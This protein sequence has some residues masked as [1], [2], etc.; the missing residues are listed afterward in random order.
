MRD[1]VL[2]LF[3]L[4]SI[5][6][7]NLTDEI[8]FRDFQSKTENRNNKSTV[9]ASDVSIKNKRLSENLR[10]MRMSQKTSSAITSFN[11]LTHNRFA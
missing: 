9:R 11:Y 8:R 5:Q 1:G 7:N 10:I 4:L 2:V 3:E 6:R